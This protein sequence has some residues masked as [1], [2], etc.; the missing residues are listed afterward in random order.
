MTHIEEATGRNE[1]AAVAPAPGEGGAVAEIIAEF[2]EIFA[3]ARTKWAR[4]AEEV[5]A[6]LRGVGM[7]VLQL[8]MRKGPITATGISQLLDM[9]KAMVSRQISKLRELDLVLAEPAAE[10]R[11][12]ILLTASDRAEE[13]LDGIRQQWAH[14]YHERFAGW[15][16]ADL[17]T[18]RSGLHRFNASA[19]SGRPDGPAKRC[20]RD[21]ERE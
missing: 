20:A 2:S 10:D 21:H 18:L 9:D 1:A 15:S 4:Y 3:F 5:H 19:D 17:E 7:M 16:A 11:R 13:M 8:V 14:A 6:D 12:V